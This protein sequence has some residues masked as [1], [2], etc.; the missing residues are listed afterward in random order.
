MLVVISDLHLTDGSTGDSISAGAFSIFVE[1]LRDLALAASWRA[2]GGYRPI[3]QIDVVLLGD[4]LD[5]I[6]SASWLDRPGSRPWSDP[7]SAEFVARVSQITGDILQHNESALEVL[8]GLSSRGGIAVPP[9]LRVAK[10]AAEN[11]AEP[12]PVRVHY[13]VGNH[14]WFFHHPSPALRAVRELVVQKMGLANPGDKPFPHDM[15]ESEELL[16]AM[17][18]HKVTARHGDLY[19]PVNYEGDRD[20]SSLGDAIVVELVTRF[21]CEVQRELGNDLPAGTLLGLREIDNVRPLLLVPVWIDGLLERTCSWPALR[22]QVKLIWD[23]LVDEFLALDFVR[24]HD[25][26]SPFDVVDGLQRVLKFSKRLPVNWASSITSWLNG[27]RGAGGDSYVAHALCEQ[28]FRNRRSKHIV[29]GHTHNVEMVPLDASYAE[30]YVLNQVYFNSGTWRRM[31]R[32][33]QLAPAEHEFI[34]A[35][36]MSYLAFFQGDERSGRPYESW[37]GVLGYHPGEVTVHRIDAGRASHAKGQPLPA[38]S[39]HE[40]A[41]HFASSMAKARIVPRRRV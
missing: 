22:K 10:P 31:H 27:L 21:G 26:Y 16:V 13:M 19:D 28:D 23:R 40:H 7:N 33:T 4:V 12:V 1:R 29:Y 35:D 2:D 17:R 32:Q 37:S 5:V 24:Q 30:G 6:R 9:A 39:L 41:P 38:P 8:R 18:R 14:D 25:T 20:G 36:V 11:E 15:S 3:E 34:A